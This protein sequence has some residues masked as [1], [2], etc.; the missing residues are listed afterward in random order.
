[1]KIRF[2]LFLTYSLLLGFS[3]ESKSQCIPNT[4]YSGAGIYPDSLPDATAG[5]TYDQDVT[6]VMLTDTL[7]LTIFDYQITNI[8]GLPIGLNWQCNS[9]QNGCVY[10]PAVNLYG[11]VKISGTPVVP[12][13]FTFT[14]TVVADVQLAGL[15]TINFDRPLTVLPSNVSNPGFSM[16]NNVGCAP[17]SVSFTNNNPGQA[18]YSW[19]FGNGLQSNV[20]NPPSQ[21]YSTPGT[22]VVTQTVTPNTTPD[23]YLT[24]VTVS[25]IPN[26]YGGP[27][28]D[29]DPYFLLY[30]PSGSQIYDSRPALN[31][32]FP[33]ISWNTPN[34]QLANGNYTVHVW[35]EDGGLFGGDD[36]LGVISFAGHGNSGTATG[37]VGGASGTLVVNYTIF[38]TPVVPLVATDTIQ[39]FATPP[40]ANIVPSGPTTIC[41]GDS[42]SLSVPD[43]SN[44]IQWYENG[45]LLV[46]TTGNILVPLTSGSYSAIATSPQ[47]CTAGSNVLAVNI[48]PLPTKPTFFINGNT[49]TTGVAGLSLQW[50]LNGSP[51]PGAN[52]I[53]YTATVGG[54]YLLC[55]TDVNGCVNCSDSLVFSGVG[56]SELK[57]N[58]FQ[59]FPN[60]SNGE[61]S[62]LWNGPLK[63]EPMLIQISDLT[64][65][66][67]HSETQTTSSSIWL[68]TNLSQGT[69]MVTLSMNG[70]TSRS[71]LVVKK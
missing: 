30:D 47:G 36:D 11:C 23:Y 7:G 19:D 6:F 28:D 12:G 17:L 40:P 64:G 25:G 8:S 45:S 65:R 2:Y 39:V 71:K 3:Q 10:D 61:F 42:L 37:T 70:L 43:T 49:F 5:V 63:S 50:F 13:T 29:P 20:E 67:V 18:A 35:D 59:L 62:I 55:G 57:G 54:T 4:T 46:G 33:P 69:Y 68:N 24:N 32:V 9:F 53:S 22:Y 56:I 41:E 66:I 15:Q 60:P 27:I 21:N 26:N 52:S 48:N 34:I 1:M 38:Q 16:T 31:G 51:I 44:N 14:V 58:S